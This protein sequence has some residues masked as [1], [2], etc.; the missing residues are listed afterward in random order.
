MTALS[1]HPG[2]IVEA[3]NRTWR[4]ERVANDVMY[5]LPLEDSDTVPHAFFLPLEGSGIRTVAQGLPPVTPGD[6]ALHHLFLRV[7][8]LSMMHGTAPLVSLQRSRVI[9]TNYQ[10]VPVMMALDMPRV[11]LLIADDVGL[12]KTVEA[13][14]VAVELLA[15]RQ[16]ER[17]LVV[18][19]PNLREQ[20]ASAFEHFFH[21]PLTVLSSATMMRLGRELPPGAN[22]WAHFPYVV[23]SLDYAKTPAVRNVLLSQ[24]W[25]LVIIDEAHT[26][27]MPSGSALG[28]SSHKEAYEFARDLA[29]RA[30]H[31]VL[32]TATP[33]NGYTSS[34]ASLVSMLDETEDASGHIR[35]PLDLVYGTP[36]APQ[37]RKARAVRHIVQRR[38][39]DVLKWF[40]DEGKRAPFPVRDE[41]EVIIEPTRTELSVYEALEKYRDYVFGGHQ[42]RTPR[43]SMLARWLMMHFLRC[44][45]SSPRTLRSALKNRIETLNAKLRDDATE[46]QISLDQQ[47]ALRDVT[48]DAGDGELFSQEELDAQLEG[49]SLLDRAQ[50]RGEIGFLETIL[51]SVIKWRA[52][53][54]SKLKRLK[55]ILAD[56]HQLGQGARTIVFTRYVGTLHYLAEELGKGNTAH[57]KVFTIDG[58]LSEHTRAERLQQFTDSPKAVLVATDAISEGLNLQ[59]AANQLVH[60]ELPWNPNRLEQRNGRIDRFKQPEPKV[61][62]RT[63]ITD[64]SF[65]LVVFERLIQKARQIRE[66]YGF[67]PAFFSSPSYID[68]ALKDSFLNRRHGQVSLFAATPEETPEEL[69]T[70]DSLARMRD[71]SFFG[72]AT[73]RLPDVE[74]RLAESCRTVGSPSEVEAFV[75][76][77]LRYF[78][79]NADPQEDG[80][81]RAERRGAAPLGELPGTFT[82]T[83]D[84]DTGA[85]HPAAMTL[86]V[87]HPIVSVLLQGVRRAAYRDLGGA[88]TAV[89][90]VPGLDTAVATFHVRARFTVGDGETG[91]VV[92]ALVP[93]HVNLDTL[94][95]A[96]PPPITG[97]C[98]PNL[99]GAHLEQMTR[100]ALGLPDLDA[101]LTARVQR[102]ADTLAAERTALKTSLQAFYPQTSAWL[103]GLERVVPAS[104]ELLAL[105]VH[106][107]AR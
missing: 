56:P 90:A 65:D 92:E 42:A 11:R 26:A 91:Q 21:L 107:P 69:A 83:L 46:E 52:T 99:P 53:Q 39:Q 17:I 24:P 31:L 67:L 59:F 43:A 30:K 86:D 16:A 106:L 80:L 100:L 55:E 96:E 87:A 15:R 66:D 48:V 57:F 70:K 85:R 34:F 19:P 82:F 38:R 2:Q 73:F 63:L 8:R 9:P 61:R 47:N 62:I 37:I 68:D 25:D 54:D 40:E 79:W 51:E 22:P 12:G 58:S 81:W 20:W 44:A 41:K 77:A 45:T 97:H 74:A 75:V 10:L 89:V 101:R 33:H 102:E 35:R 84:A 95:D 14:L 36:E 71:E 1:L 78:G 23:T 72:Q 49:L 13:G 29:R 28:R 104:Q 93:L 27:A 98:P 32:A 6:L 60:Y 94:L 4:V 105:T 64:R 7:F 18:C 50:I 88:R 5:A 103:D 3:R 76:D